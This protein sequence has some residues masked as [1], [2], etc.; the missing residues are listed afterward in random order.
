MA[1]KRP[2]RLIVCYCK[3]MG[4]CPT[5]GV[6]AVASAL[7]A[8]APTFMQYIY[9]LTLRQQSIITGNCVAVLDCFCTAC[10]FSLLAP[11]C[12]RT[13]STTHNW[14]GDCCISATSQLELELQL[15]LL[16]IWGFPKIRGYHF[17]GPNSKDYSISGSIL[18]Y[19]LFWE[20]TT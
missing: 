13:T 15:L 11:P 1:P 7:A 19:P 16:Q 5:V 8:V 20:T 9:L 6:V 14:Y 2:G 17:G 3:Q 12:L 10:V 18:G 4:L